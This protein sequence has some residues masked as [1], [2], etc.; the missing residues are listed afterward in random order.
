MSPCLRSHGAEY[1]DFDGSVVA[2]FLDPVAALEVNE[3]I[4]Q[5]NKCIG[6]A[7]VP[8]LPQVLSDQVKHRGEGAEIVV[9][10]DVEFD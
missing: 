8:V 4:P 7:R 3:V 2:L 9:F 6:V 10:L 5:T 1:L